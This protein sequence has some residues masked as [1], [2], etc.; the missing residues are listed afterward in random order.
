MFIDLLQELKVNPVVEITEN[1]IGAPVPDDDFSLK[2]TLNYFKM[3]LPAKLLE[4]Y[5]SMSSCK[6]EWRCNL[7]DH[8]D[9]KKMHSNDIFVSGRVSILSIEKLLE[10]D[11]KM[12]TPLWQ[13][14]LDDNERKDL[15]N[16][17]YMDYND[18]YTRVGFIA[19]KKRLD[20][21]NIYFLT[22]NSES[23]IKSEFTFDMYIQNMI[24]NKGYS[25][26]Q[27]N[28]F[29]PASENNSMMIHYLGQIFKKQVI[30]AS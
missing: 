18:D 21:E 24:K 27:Y 20:I 2:L 29:F 8:P 6:I 30:K 25:G 3:E 7:D 23:F 19:D 1:Y 11:K 5:H 22:Q 26:W 10:F 4:F 9:I 16:F 13:S 14:N 12:T 28:Y 15:E 17:R